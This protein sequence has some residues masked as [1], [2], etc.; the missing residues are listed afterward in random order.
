MILQIILLLNV[1]A[2]CFCKSF[3]TSTFEPVILQINPLFNFGQAILQGILLFNI[4]AGLFRFS[5]LGQMILQGILL[6]IF[7]QMNLQIILLFHIR[8]D[9]STNSCY[10]SRHGQI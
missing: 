3:C 7:G 8:A 4:W 9:D 10:N 1:G 6:S 5:T 2:D